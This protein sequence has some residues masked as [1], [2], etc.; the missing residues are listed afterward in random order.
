M[1][2]FALIVLALGA[3]HLGELYIKTLEAPT[4]N[5]DQIVKDCQSQGYF[6]HGILTFSCEQMFVV[7]E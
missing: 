6:T 1:K 5:S 3:F 4:N 7:E 2:Y